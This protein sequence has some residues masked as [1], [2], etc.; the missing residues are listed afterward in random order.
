MNVKL[1]SPCVPIKQAPD[2]RSSLLKLSRM[3]LRTFRDAVLPQM[4]IQ[5]GGTN[6]NKT[7]FTAKRIVQK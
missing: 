3:F 4:T 2:K 7:K 6:T 5:N 1:C